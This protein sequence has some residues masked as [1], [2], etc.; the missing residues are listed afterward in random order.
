MRLSI[1]KLFTFGRLVGSFAEFEVSLRGGKMFLEDSGK[2][3]VSFGGVG[4]DRMGDR[5]RVVG[6]IKLAAVRI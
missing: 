6:D 4:G 5:I 1:E 3:A 2:M